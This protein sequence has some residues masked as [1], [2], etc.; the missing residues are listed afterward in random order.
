MVKHSAFVVTRKALVVY[1][2]KVFGSF[3]VP[4]F[5]EKRV[6]LLFLKSLHDC[7]E[8]LFA[9]VAQETLIGVAHLDVDDFLPRLHGPCQL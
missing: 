3:E 4:K 7:V 8:V 6:I 5:V 1:T 9:N 2:S